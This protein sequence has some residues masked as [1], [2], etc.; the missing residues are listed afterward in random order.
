[1]YLQHYAND[2]GDEARPKDELQYLQHDANDNS[3]QAH[4]KDELQYLQHEAN[5]DSDQACPKDELQYL[6]HD[7]NDAGDEARPEEESRSHDA[8]QHV[9]PN[10]NTHRVRIKHKSYG[11]TGGFRLI[12]KS[13][14]VWFSFE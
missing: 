13:N 6:Q 12:R 3:D 11:Q 7:A 14:T 2:D 1:M 8:Q 9:H 4:P 5:D 10:C